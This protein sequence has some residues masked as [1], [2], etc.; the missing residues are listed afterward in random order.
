MSEPVF[1]GR[2]QSLA[3]DPRSG[4][5]RRR[6]PAGTGGKPQ[7]RLDE[8]AARLAQAS[9][10]TQLET[11]VVEAEPGPLRDLIGPGDVLV[12]TAGPFLKVGRP[13]WP[14]R[15]TRARS[16]W[17][18]PVSK[19]RQSASA[20][21]RASA[22]GLV[23]EG[24]YAF[25]GGRVVSERTAVHVTSFEIDG[26]RKEAFSTGCSEHFGRP[27]LRPRTADTPPQACRLAGHPVGR[28]RRRRAA[29]WRARP[30]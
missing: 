28:G 19:L 20:G 17:T 10:G 18:P 26:Q 9:D 15:P 11:A 3:K 13:P 27:R 8:V 21:T 6:Y 12:S 2:R 5:P 16:T 29:R 1:P 7:G 23:L 4:P 25:R 14:R 22:A 30:G 24:G